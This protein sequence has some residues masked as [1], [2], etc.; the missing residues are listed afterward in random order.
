[1]RIKIIV[2][3]LLIGGFCYAQNSQLA[4][5][6]FRKGEY[7]KAANLYEQLHKKN[8]IRRDYFKKLLSCYQLTEDFE[9]ASNLLDLQ[10]ETFPTQP[11]LNIELGYNYQLQNQR[12]KATPYYEEALLAIE[13]NPNNGYVIGT[14]FKDNHLLDYALKAYL[15]AMELKPTLNYNV[16]VASIY[17]CLL[18]TSPS[19]RDQRGSR[20]PS[21]A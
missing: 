14:T 3:F 18:Y 4:Y 1:M 9:K 19:P 11:H 13:D 7:K 6:Y 21:S 12:E 8:K 15:R 2:V 16:Y 17:G 5:S 20:M 10:M